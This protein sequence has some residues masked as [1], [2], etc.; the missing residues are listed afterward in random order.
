M[1]IRPVNP[2]EDAASQL[3]AIAKALTVNAEIDDATLAH[4]GLADRTKAILEGRTGEN[5]PIPVTPFCEISD[6]RG[7]HEVT[8]Q[9]QG[10][11]G[12]GYLRHD[13]V[14]QFLV[15]GPPATENPEKE[16]K[17]LR[18]ITWAFW[19][20]IH[21]NPTLN[22]ATENAKVVD[23][24]CILVERGGRIYWMWR[25]RVQIELEKIWR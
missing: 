24:D 11:D 23:D 18:S 19:V 16:K 2:L 4:V 5:G 12:Q 3:L 20:A 25:T 9:G 17:F 8:S 6:G 1:P 14:V 22:D 7:S 21:A 13:F 10:S 15:P